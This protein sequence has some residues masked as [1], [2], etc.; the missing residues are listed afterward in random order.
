[1]WPVTT[2]PAE[3]FIFDGYAATTLE[4]IAKLGADN[5]PARRGPA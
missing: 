2:P 1:L 3:L 4:Q 5:P